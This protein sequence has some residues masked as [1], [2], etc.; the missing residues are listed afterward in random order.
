MNRLCTTELLKNKFR[1][2]KATSEEKIGITPPG[3]YGANK[4]GGFV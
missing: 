4:A 3:G 2:I 1:S